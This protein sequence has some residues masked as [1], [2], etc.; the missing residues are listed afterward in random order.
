[1]TQLACNV[2][3][4]TRRA[5]RTPLDEALWAAE[6]TGQWLAKELGV[7]VSQVSRWRRGASIP[8]YVTQRRIAKVLGVSVT[9]LWP[10]EDA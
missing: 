3:S 8:M 5:V 7:N 4:V 1:M 9:S 2:L 6:R 10:P